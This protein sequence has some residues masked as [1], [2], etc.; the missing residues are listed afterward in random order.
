MHHF[1]HRDGELHAEDVPLQRI[2]DE[3][4]T[5]TYV[6][7]AATLTRHY[8][9]MDAA[10]QGVD[11]TIC[12]AVKANGN[13]AVLQL[14][15]RLGSGF[16]IVSVGELRRVLLAG[17]DA[18][19]V[20][21]SGVGKRDDEIAE[22]LRVG[23]LCLNVESAGELERIERVAETLGLRAPISLRVNPEVDPKTHKYIAT[24]LRTSKFGV[25]ME[26][27]PELYR[28][29]SNSKHLRVVGVD[30]HIG[31]QI[32]ELAPLIEAVEKVLGLVE[33]LRA[34][35][36]TLEHLDIGG[37][38]GIAYRDETPVTPHELG[39]LVTAMARAHYLKLL[40]EP[41]RV[42][43][44]N[45]GVLLTRVLGE[46]SN[47]DRHFVIVDAAMNDL[48]RPALYDA[49]HAIQPVV[50][51]A[52]RPDRVV[53]VVGPVCESSDFLAQQR[54]L[55]VVE[56]GELLAVMGCGAYGFSMAS[57]YNSRPRAAEVLVDGAHFHIVRERETVEDG[58]RGEHLL[59]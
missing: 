13:L 4:G 55:P 15:A 17:G 58:Y 22:A 46:K 2:A 28:K 7:S 10:L 38:L 34:E 43:A 42:I 59:P 5:P 36:I 20:V 30:S 25:A 52:G 51:V 11:H 3:V 35:G 32:L 6:Y 24:G 40:V 57:T 45:A 41:G 53:D 16:D 44:G 12:Y 39:S 48:L 14:L 27:A 31:S 37:G 47:G 56:P 8:Q 21:F 1:H 18:A 23:V 54:Q 50:E 9:V 33:R 29:A 49:Y 19:K 26:V